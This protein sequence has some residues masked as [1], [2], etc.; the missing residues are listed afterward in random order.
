M[1]AKIGENDATASSFHETTNRNGRFLLDLMDGCNLTNLSTSFQKKKGKLWTFQYP[2]GQKGQIDHI[3]INK[4]WGNSAMNCEAYNTYHCLNSDHRPCSAKLR[5]CLRANKKHASTSTNYDWGLLMN[6]QTVKHAYTVE[7]KNRFQALQNQNTD[8]NAEN[9]YQNIILA[10]E[11]S[12]KSHIPIRKKKK[13]KN[14]WESDEVSKKRQALHKAFEQNRSN[15]TPQNNQIV[16]NAKEELDWAYLKE[17]ENYIKN[18]VKKLENAHQNQK[19]KLVWNI[20]NEISARKNSKK[21]QIRAKNPEERIK[22]WKKH[23]KNLLGQPPNIEDK[24][25][26][27]VFEP[28][29]IVTA[30]FT[31]DELLKAI[32]ALKNSKAAG[33]DGIPC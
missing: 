25:V 3:L 31:E 2:N 5:L 7:V 6:D 15:P 22:L 23:F 18:Q 10:H 20:V 12:G 21:G 27:K 13:K 14:T 8:T 4:K 26:E 9:M 24:T 1:N 33:L 28:L 11:E 30:D 17:Q 16:Q 19:T 29:P 32:K